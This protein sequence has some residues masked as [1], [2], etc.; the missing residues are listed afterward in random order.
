MQT[1]KRFAAVQ[2]TFHNHINQAQQIVD[3]FARCFSSSHSSRGRVE[4]G[5]GLAPA[6]IPFLPPRD[7]GG[8]IHRQIGRRSS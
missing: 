8:S 3:L 6:R 7:N 2:S 4:A 1:L 5:K